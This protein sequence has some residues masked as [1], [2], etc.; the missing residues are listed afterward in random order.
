MKLE[1]FSDYNSLSDHAAEE[2]ISLVNR[3][4][5]AV[6]CL[7][8]GDSPRL[9]CK[10]LA[11]RSIREEIDFS[12]STFIGLDEWLG[13]PPDNE[14]SCHYFFRHLVLEPLQFSDEQFYMFDALTSNPREECR[15][16]DELISARDGIDLMIVGIGM[17]GHIGFNEPG[18]SFENLSH[19]ADLDETTVSV[20][21]KY[22]DRP[23]KLSQGITIGFKHLLQS[24]KLILLA[25]GNKKAGVIK[26]ALEGTVSTAFPASV[27][28]QHPNCVVMIDE[29]AATLLSKNY[30]R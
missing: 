22:F 29:E 5:N 12:Q 6:F 9:A 7:A 20:G 15:K 26:K 28:Q 13:I 21:Q 2:V 18:T 8:S 4:P 14:G 17:N 1:I 16:M 23:M 27:V 3:K 24:R 19:V 11:E 30:S 25:N 10:L